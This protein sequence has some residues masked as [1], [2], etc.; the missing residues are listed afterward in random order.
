MKLQFI[1]PRQ[2]LKP[3]ISKIWLVENNLGLVNHGTLI[4]PNARPKIIIPFKNALTT[5]DNYKTTICKENGV[6]FIGIRDVP[7]TL[8]TPEGATGSIGLE[9]T[10][11]GAYKFLNTPMYEL[12]NNLFSF[13]ELYGKEGKQLLKLIEENENPKQKINIIQG[14]LLNQLKSMERNNLILN[15]SVNFISSLQGLASIKELEKKT[16]YS[17]RYLDMLFK[18]YLGISPKTYSTIIRFQHF[19]KTFGENRSSDTIIQSALESYY[20]QSHF[21]KEFKRYTGYAPT[22]YSKL[23]NDFGK[24]F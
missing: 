3:Y 17:K 22:Q 8:G 15:Y 11:D 24:H 19:Y 16:G 12:T 1:Q 10:T 4:A 14:F 13:S 21:I 5:T 2:E 7:V 23:N 9:F 18:N 6:Y 20:D